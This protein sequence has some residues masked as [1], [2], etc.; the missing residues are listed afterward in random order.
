MNSQNGNTGLESPVNSQTGK[1]ALHKEASPELA[2]RDAGGTISP[3]RAARVPDPDP[4]TEAYIRWW[5][6]HRG[7]EPFDYEELQRLYAAIPNEEG[8]MKK[9]EV[10]AE[11]QRG[12][13]AME[14]TAEK[15]NVGL[16]TENTKI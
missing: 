9:E 11:A 16:A 6:M 8:K 5:Q 14:L 4:E 3:P 10:N 12:E 2:G 15:L 1:S 7:F 13:G